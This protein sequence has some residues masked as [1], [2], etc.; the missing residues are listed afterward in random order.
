MFTDVAVLYFNTA[1][2]LGIDKKEEERNYTSRLW[3]DIVMNCRV[4][5]WR[6][7]ELSFP[8]WYELS[9]LW[10]VIAANRRPPTHPSQ[11]SSAKKSGRNG[12]LNIQE[13]KE[14]GG[15]KWASVEQ[16]SKFPGKTKGRNNHLNFVKF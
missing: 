8:F 3:I 6:S 1:C 4:T 16:C 13:E 12:L 9:W 7:Y 14:G 10:I 5:N 2:H 15:K 11:S